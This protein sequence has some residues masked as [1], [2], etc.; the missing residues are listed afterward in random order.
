MSYQYTSSCTVNTSQWRQE[1]VSSLL[2]ALFL[3]HLY[4][5]HCSIFS[6][7]VLLS[8]SDMH[9]TSVIIAIFIV[10]A[11]PTNNSLGDKPSLVLGFSY[12]SHIVSGRAFSTHIGIQSTLKV[13]SCCFRN[14]FFF[15]SINST[16]IVL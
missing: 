6:N 5:Q 4:S 11:T 12:N 1:L 2:P 9:S 15:F 3:I 16:P 10:G 14:P 8:N 7:R 13:F